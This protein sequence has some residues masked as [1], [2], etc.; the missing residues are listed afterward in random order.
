MADRRPECPECGVKVPT[1]GHLTL[2]PCP[3]ATV[4]VIEEWTP[5]KHIIT[6]DGTVTE[7]DSSDLGYRTSPV[8]SSKSTVTHVPSTVTNPDSTVTVM[9]ARTVTETRLPKNRAW[10]QRNPDRYRKWRREYMRRRR[11]E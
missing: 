9:A 2:F 4:E 11:A 10:E 7:T 1:Q 6:I 8:V 3:K 5:T